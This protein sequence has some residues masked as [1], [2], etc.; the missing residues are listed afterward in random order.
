MQ[1]QTY[2]FKTTTCTWMY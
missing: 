1:L 2:I